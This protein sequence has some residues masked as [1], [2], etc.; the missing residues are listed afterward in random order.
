MNNQ[1]KNLPVRALE[2]ITTFEDGD[3]NENPWVTGQLK[4]ELTEVQAYDA[5]WPGLPRAYPPYP[6]SAWAGHTSRGF[7]ALRGCQDAGQRRGNNMRDYEQREQAVA[8]DIY[9]KIFES[10]G[11]LQP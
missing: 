2:K 4:A 3:P 10:Q 9:R 8:R 7:A 6:V 1:N 11:L 5:N